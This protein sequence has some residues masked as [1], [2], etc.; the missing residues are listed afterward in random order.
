MLS[1]LVVEKVNLELFRGEIH[2][3]I[4]NLKLQASPDSTS[5]T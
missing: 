3:N 2:F 4:K 5:A 1:V